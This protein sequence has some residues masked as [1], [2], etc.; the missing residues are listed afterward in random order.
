MF[1]TLN[2]N[3]SDKSCACPNQIC[4][5]SVFVYF[6]FFTFVFHNRLQ[7]ADN[8]IKVHIV[9]KLV[10][11]GNVFH[12]LQSICSFFLAIYFWGKTHNHRQTYR[13]LV[14]QL[15]D[16]SDYLP[17]L[18]HTMT[19]SLKT[20]Q[21]MEYMHTWNLDIRSS[22]L[23]FVCI[24]SFSVFTL[25]LGWISNFSQLGNKFDQNGNCS[26]RSE[27][28]VDINLIFQPPKFSFLPSLFFRCPQ[29]AQ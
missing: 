21:E 13:L 18:T 22:T 16:Q 9:S 17:E 14:L 19:P 15:F 5:Y 24:F 29:T 8:Y 10:Y 27:M 3:G 4:L 2:H 12:Q 1:I 7:N 23:I 28:A 11:L 25:F 6:M 20:H 26:E